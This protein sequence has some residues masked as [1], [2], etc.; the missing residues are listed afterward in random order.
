MDTERSLTIAAARISALVYVLAI[1]LLF[2]RRR[3]ESRALWTVG[4]ALYLLH[5]WFAFEYFYGW[6]ATK[7]YQETAAQTMQLFGVNFGGGLYLNYLFTI[8]WSLDCAWWWFDSE[9]YKTRSTVISTSVHA[10]MAFM[11]VNGTIV[12]WVLRWWHN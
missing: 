11:V 8:L 12:V 1:W 3:R 7:A 2:I 9:S 4:L 5:V 10:F 6:S